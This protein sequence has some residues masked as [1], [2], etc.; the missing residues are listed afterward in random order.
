MLFFQCFK[1]HNLPLNNQ[2]DRSL[3]T[4]ELKS[5]MYAALDSKT[6]MRRTM[7]SYQNIRPSKSL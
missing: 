2:N 1:S 7:M 5:H 4:L 3:C 6:C